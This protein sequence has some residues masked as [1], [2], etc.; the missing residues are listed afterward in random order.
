LVLLVAQSALAADYIAEAAAGLA[1]SSVYVAPGTAGTDSNT[2]AALGA[3]LTAGDGIVLVMLPAGASAELGLDIPTIAARLS[4]ALGGKRIIG[5]AVG[6]ELAGYAPSLPS[7]VASDQMHRAQSV[8]NDPIT[9]LGTFAGNIHIWQGEHPTPTP[10][11]VPP[12]PGSESGS[13][14]PIAILLVMIVVLIGGAWLAFVLASGKLTE[15]VVDGTRFNAPGPV[16]D[17]LARIALEGDRVEDPTL[18]RTVRQICVDIE[19]YFA[20]SSGDMKGDSALFSKNLTDVDR[21]LTKYIDVQD[22]RRYY[23]DPDSLMV[24]VKEALDDF[25]DY[26][27]TSIRNGNEVA[28]RAYKLNAYVLSAQRE[29]TGSG[30][31]PGG[32]RP[33]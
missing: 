29:V 11:P 5:L 20:S 27:I 30:L 18:S 3:R 14:F 15:Q 7:G 1:H 23:K 13:G 33:T 6:D 2:A 25:S 32:R 19:H 10:A 26:V 24:Q 22:N 9:A 28:L 31:D 12:A 17:L 8:S 21:V 4:E 16:R